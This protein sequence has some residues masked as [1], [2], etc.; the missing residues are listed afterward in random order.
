MTDAGLEAGGFTKEKWDE[1]MQLLDKDNSGDVDKSE[2]KAVFEKMFP[3]KTEDEFEAQ[4]NKMDIDGDGN[5]SVVELAK[6][7]GFNLEAESAANMSDEQI[8]EALQMQAALV[9]M[10]KA[11]AEKLAAER[12]AKIEAD[13]AE[14]AK[15]GLMET[16]VEKDKTIKQVK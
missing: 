13:E 3:D 12:Q 9:E 2:Y 4:W 15:N 10:E 7:Y 1:M 5:L 11:K 16:K 6:H 8:L 14:R